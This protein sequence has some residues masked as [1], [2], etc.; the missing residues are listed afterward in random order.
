MCMVEFRSGTAAHTFGDVYDSHVAITV[1][2]GGSGG[3]QETLMVCFNLGLEDSSLFPA[4]V[5]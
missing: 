4:T 5:L 3:Q 1:Y 2:D